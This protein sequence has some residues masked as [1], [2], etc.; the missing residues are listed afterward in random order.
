L[1]CSRA[2]IQKLDAEGVLHR[3]GDTYPLDR[4][5]VAYIRFL[6]RERKASPRSEAETWFQQQ[7]AKLIEFRIRKMAGEMM[8]VQK[9]NELTDKAIGMVLSELSSLPV[10][11]AGRDLTA[12]RAAE[13]AIRQMRKRL[14]EGYARL[15]DEAG[16]PKDDIKVDR[17]PY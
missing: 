4:N 17:V 15:A 6:R 13:E 2:Y 5:R 11:I 10:I 7:K 12:R 9:H 1:D 14:A 3:E 8:P 16:E